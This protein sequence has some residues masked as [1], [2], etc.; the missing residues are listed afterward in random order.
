MELNMKEKIVTLLKEEEVLVC[1]E[2]R[3]QAYFLI[4]KRELNP[5]FLIRGYDEKRNSVYERF[6][7]CDSF[8]CAKSTLQTLLSAY[9]IFR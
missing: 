9:Q 7:A 2:F 8:D 6:I 5:S 4:A 1:L 3:P